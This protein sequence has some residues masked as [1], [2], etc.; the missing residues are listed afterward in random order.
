MR[1]WV[2]GGVLLVGC[3]SNTAAK[4][5]SISPIQSQELFLGVEATQ[6]TPDPSNPR[7]QLEA[8]Q[9]AE[10]EHMHQ[11]DVAFE[12]R[13]RQGCASPN[14]I[15]GAGRAAGVNPYSDPIAEGRKP[16]DCAVDHDKRV[17]Y[18]KFW[19]WARANYNRLYVGA[20]E[21]CSVTGGYVTGRQELWYT[22]EHGSYDHE[23]GDPSFETGG[24]GIVPRDP[25][26]SLSLGG[27]S[28]RKGT[29]KTVLTFVSI[30]GGLDAFR[31]PGTGDGHDYLTKSELCKDV[32]GFPPAGFR[33]K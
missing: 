25:S 16:V 13:C 14:F 11:I 5:G 32:P 27:S 6:M 15:A 28:C 1:G 29:P 30:P 33:E 24:A 19:H 22:D 12:A 7:I 9:K 21:W 20:Q 26:F 3:A 18:A 8:W 31:T 2:L 10:D 23:V 17:Q 4:Q